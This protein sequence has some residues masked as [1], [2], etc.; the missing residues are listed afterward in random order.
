MNPPNS[1]DH[2]MKET[3]HFPSTKDGR[4]YFTTT[5]H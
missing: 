2:D 4:K 3:E 5:E 1:N